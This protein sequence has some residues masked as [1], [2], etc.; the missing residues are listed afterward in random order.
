MLSVLEEEKAQGHISKR[1]LVLLAKALGGPVFWSIILGTMVVNQV[2]TLAQV[3]LLGKWAKAY[4]VQNRE[5]V[6]VPYYLSIYGGIVVVATITYAVGSWVWALGSVRSGVRIH[7]ELL[8][9]VFSATVR[10]LDST[11]QGALSSR[12]PSFV[13]TR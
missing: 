9:A 4:E 11:P 2:A 13:R 7:A 12:F 3:G 5:D 6:N 1:S 8:D 10:W